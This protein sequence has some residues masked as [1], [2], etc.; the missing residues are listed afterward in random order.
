MVGLEVDEASEMGVVDIL[1]EE[2]TLM[3]VVD[4][5]ERLQDETDA[6]RVPHGTMKVQESMV[7]PCAVF[8]G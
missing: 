4:E 1:A 3:T 5:V 8:V 2:D 7:V 6:D